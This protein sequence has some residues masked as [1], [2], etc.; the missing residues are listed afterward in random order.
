MASVEAIDLFLLQVPDF[1][2]DRDPVKDT[3]LVR[4]RAAAHEGWGECEAAPL[5]SLAA[6][7]TPESHS[8]SQPVAASVI[9]QKLDDPADIAAITRSV[10]TKSMNVLQAPHVFSGVE[11]ALW[12]LLGKMHQEPAYRLLG[13]REAFPK[14]PYVVMPFASTPQETFRRMEQIRASGF[15]AVKTGWNG[16]GSGNLLADRAQLAAAREGLGKDARLFLDAARVWGTDVSAAT[17]Y[18][19]LLEEFSVEWVEEP[20]IPTALDAYADLARKHGR[21]HVAAGEN[22]NSVAHARQLLDIGGIGIIQ[23]DCGRVGGI[24]AAAEIARFADEGGAVYLNHTYTSH[25]ALSA[26]LSAYAGLERHS[27]CEYPSDRTS[28]SWAICAD[29]LEIGPGGMIVSPEAPGLGIA[30]NLDG[31]EDRVVDLEIRFSDRILYRTPCL[32]T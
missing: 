28:L 8:T 24:G 23:I 26:S 9:G 10:A 3:L 7:V 27:L 1:D 21:D 29:H 14:V 16:F 30:M 18:Q 13:Y 22:A 11:M 25:L 15:H 20:F 31:V 6:F 4:V 12:D 5:V 17:R 2:P 19:P 32:R